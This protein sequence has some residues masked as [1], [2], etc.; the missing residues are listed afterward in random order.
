MALLIP[1]S[2][3][4][5]V[6][7]GSSFAVSQATPPA[8]TSNLPDLAVVSQ[9]EVRAADGGVVLAGQFGA[10][11]TED[12]ETEREATLSAAGALAGARGTA[13][14]ELTPR[15]HQTERELELDVE[16]LPANT[17]FT[18]V[19]D[20]QTLTTFTT[21]ADGEAEVELKDVR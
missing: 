16:G 3:L 4:F 8:T 19:V 13:E 21:D 10:A 9:I 7:F 15:G 20:G 6:L 11:T 5:M 12:G 18:V 1:V 14:I 17:S 2:T